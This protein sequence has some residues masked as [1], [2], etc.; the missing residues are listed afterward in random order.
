MI[1]GLTGDQRFFLNY[2]QS[3]REKT[4][5]EIQIVIVKT[6]PHSPDMFRVN[7]PLSNLD[8]FYETYK[9][10]PGDKMFRPKQERVSI[11]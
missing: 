9:L 7:V 8:A 10:K 1:D 5:D 2:A 11:W 6:D 4:R 3:H